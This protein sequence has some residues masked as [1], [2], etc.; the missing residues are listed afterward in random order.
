LAYVKHSFI[1]LYYIMLLRVFCLIHSP[2][3]LVRVIV[4]SL[5]YT[6]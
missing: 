5:L 1:F 2:P 6:W 4:R 3:F